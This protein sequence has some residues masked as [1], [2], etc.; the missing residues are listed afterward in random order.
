MENGDSAAD[1]LAADKTQ[2]LEKRTV[3]N[4]YI[5]DKRADNLKNLT[6]S[7]ISRSE[8]TEIGFKYDTYH[9][10]VSKTIWG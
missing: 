3:L 6:I 4:F 1:D 10:F 5:L 9:I 7:A 2:P 8:Y